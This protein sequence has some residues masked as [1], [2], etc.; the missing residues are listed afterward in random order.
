M[1]HSNVHVVTRCLKCFFLYG[2]Y[3]TVVQAP[4]HCTALYSTVLC[5][6]SVVSLSVAF[7]LRCA[8]LCLPASWCSVRWRVTPLR[9]ALRERLAFA[10]YH[11]GLHKTLWPCFLVCLLVAWLC[12]RRV[13]HYEAFGPSILASCIWLLMC[14]IAIEDLRHKTPWYLFFELHDN[15]SCKGTLMFQ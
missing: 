9:S 2:L 7:Q 5:A 10:L 12:C 3:R 6:C 8:G 1:C 15:F 14:F 4:V 13:L 11:I